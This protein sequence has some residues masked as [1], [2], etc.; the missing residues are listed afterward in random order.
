MKYVMFESPVEGIFP[1]VFP[2][3]IDHNL[4]VQGMRATYPG[5]VPTSAGFCSIGTDDAE[6]PKVFVWG[7]SVGLKLKSQ[8]DDAIFLEKLL[9]KRD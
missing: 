7:E 9:I 1:I 5:I 4:F 2:I 3:A 6:K 8:P